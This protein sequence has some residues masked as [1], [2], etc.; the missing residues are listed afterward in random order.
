MAW[1]RHVTGAHRGGEKASANSSSWYPRYPR[2]LGWRVNTCGRR[3]TSRP[4]LSRRWRA[5]ARINRYVVTTLP[6]SPGAYA[7]T[8]AASS[9]A[10]K[11]VASWLSCFR[12][13]RRSV[14]ASSKAYTVVAA[15]RGAG[16][17]RQPAPAVIT[18][19]LID[20][21]GRPVR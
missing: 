18:L 10:Y 4:P 7:G 2:S 16:T 8:L 12:P 3:L 14:A 1:A 11:V 13:Y 5:G 21:A 19:R 17:V 9:K 15:R 6:R 20:R